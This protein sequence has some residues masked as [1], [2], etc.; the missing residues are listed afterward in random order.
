MQLFQL[1][2]ANNDYSLIRGEGGPC[3]HNIDILGYRDSDSGFIPVPF[4][5][6]MSGLVNAAYAAPPDQVPMGCIDLTTL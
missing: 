1:L 3:C 6:D 5:F 4:D 2:I